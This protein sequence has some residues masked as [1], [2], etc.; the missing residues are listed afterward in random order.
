MV[1]VPNQPEP[2]A[3][4]GQR[5]PNTLGE[6]FAIEAGLLCPEWRHFTP[7]EGAEDRLRDL[8][9]ITRFMT[10]LAEGPGAGRMEVTHEGLLALL[11]LLGREMEMIHHLMAVK[12]DVKI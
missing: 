11:H 4:T 12:H 7:P 6:R 8:M 1:V 9:V 10:D 3:R 2:Q 5:P